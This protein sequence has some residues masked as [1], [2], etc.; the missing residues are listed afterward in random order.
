MVFVLKRSDVGQI[1]KQIAE[2]ERLGWLVPENADSVRLTIRGWH[3]YTGKNARDGVYNR[4]RGDRSAEYARRPTTRSGRRDGGVTD[5]D[6]RVRTPRR[7]ETRKT[8]GVGGDGRDP[9]SVTP[10]SGPEK[11]SDIIER[12]RTQRIGGQPE[13]VVE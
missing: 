6:G 8:G 3:R 2:L 13:G 10:Y 12:L 5:G 4:D 7:D 11:P 9:A 1:D